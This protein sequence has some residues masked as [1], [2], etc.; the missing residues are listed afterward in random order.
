MTTLHPEVSV[1]LSGRDGNA[2]CILGLCHQA[3]RLAGLSDAKIDAFT[4]EATSGDYDHLIR[5]TLLW[6]SCS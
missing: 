3:S 4:E 1:Q 5:T 2:F 6:F